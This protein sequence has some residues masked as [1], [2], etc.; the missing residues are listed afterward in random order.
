VADVEPTPRQVAEEVVTRAH[1]RDRAARARDQRARVV[2][3]ALVDDPRA[4]DAD[5]VARLAAGDRRA[6]EHD[7]RAAADD[8]G[9][10]IHA[11]LGADAPD[12]ADPD[13]SERE[14]EVLGLLAR[15]LT[16][17]EIAA[18]LFLSVNTVKTH[19]RTLYR[20]LGVST[21]VAAAIW[22]RDHGY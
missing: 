16:A 12:G 3:D 17:R 19:T 20:K 11:L 7:R 4:Y 15:G 6:A 1:H 10:L 22:A 13:L 18:D 8:R 2:A 14:R 21:R 5:E 9:R